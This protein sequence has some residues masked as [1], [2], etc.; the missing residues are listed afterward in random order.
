MINIFGLTL[1]FL[2]LFT[3]VAQSQL[4]QNVENRN[5]ESIG[6]LIPSK[7]GIL[8]RPVSLPDGKKNTPSLMVSHLGLYVKMNSKGVEELVSSGQFI[9]VPGKFSITGKVISMEKSQDNELLFFPI[10]D[11]EEAGIGGWCHEKN[12]EDSVVGYVLKLKGGQIVIPINSALLD[13][14]IGKQ[15]PLG[16]KSHSSKPT[17]P[18]DGKIRTKII[19][20]KDEG[21]VVDLNTGEGLYLRFDDRD[22]DNPI[23]ISLAD[24]PNY[25]VIETDKSVK[26][27]ARKLRL[28]STR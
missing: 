18:S 19:S 12:S 14:I 6:T 4:G 28:K 26:E 10:D 21:A 20:F 11:V 17:Y 1:I 27:N 7:E 22:L 16:Q 25:T 15:D 5:T 8:Y 13:L 9:P 2:I 23:F 24:D 3:S